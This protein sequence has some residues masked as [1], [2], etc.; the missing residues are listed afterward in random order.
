MT[1]KCAVITCRIS[2]LN[3]NSQIKINISARVWNSTLIEDY[4]E[5]DWVS[6]NSV[7]EVIIEDE[8]VTQ[9]NNSVNVTSVSW[10]IFSIFCSNLCFSID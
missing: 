6:L 8:T 10:E 1:A 3:E 9:S 2:Q 4:K 7:A 5:V